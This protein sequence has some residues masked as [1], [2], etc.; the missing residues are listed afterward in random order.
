MMLYQ[1]TR[2]YNCFILLYFAVLNAVN[3]SNL[4]E[5]RKRLVSNTFLG[6]RPSLGQI[7]QEPWRNAATGFISPGFSSEDILT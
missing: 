5:E 2:I 4:R 6:H 1:K 7:K 3:K